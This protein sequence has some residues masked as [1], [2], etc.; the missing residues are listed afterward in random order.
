M[1]KIVSLVLF[2][3]CALLATGC[4]NTSLTSDVDPGVDLSS[5]NKFYVQKFSSDNRGIEVMIADRLNAMG[6]QA[7]YGEE[8]TPSEPVDVVVTYQD[9]WMWDI[10]MYMLELS[11]DLRHPETN[12]KM[13]TGK[14]YRTSLA[15]K[16]PEEMVKEVL[17]KIFA[18]PAEGE[19]K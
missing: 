5:M 16:S 3:F 19:G 17:E 1:K 6:K 14:S 10:T 15:R 7:S 2:S 12:Y 9:K 11:M 4:V 18:A 13:A 8:E